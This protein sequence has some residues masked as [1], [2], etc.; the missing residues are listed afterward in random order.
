[1]RTLPAALPALEFFNGLGGF[2]AEGREYVVTL[3]EGQWTPAPWSNV[4]ANPEFGFQVS[5]D[6]AG[7]T[8]SLNAQQ[9]QLTP[10]SNDPVSNVPAEAIYIRDEETGMSGVRRRCPYGNPPRRTWSA[11]GSATADSN[12]LARHFTGP[13]AIRAAQG[14]VK[15]SRLKIGNRSNAARQL[16]ITHYVDWVLG[17]QRG[18]SA[19][20]I[21]TQIEPKTAALLARNPWSNEFPSR[22]AFMDM[23]GRQSSCTA[24]RAEFIG[25]HGS[26]AEPAALLGSTDCRINAAA[27]SIPAARCRRRSICTRRNC[28]ADA[29]SRRGSLIGRRGGSHRTLPDARL[30]RRP[31][32]VTNFWVRPWVPFK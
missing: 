12:I 6:G 32:D 19:P 4:I 21:V 10:W 15:I 28:G 31:E 26:L 8:W 25:R 5:A 20:F 29:V 22:V 9:N 11:T 2:S 3:E 17:N 16:S 13:C 14:P 30:G 27:A 24:D 23:A 1:V 18:K 7:S